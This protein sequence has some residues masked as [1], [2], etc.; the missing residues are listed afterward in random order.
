MLQWYL[1]APPSYLNHLGI[2]G[3]THDRH[4]GMGVIKNPSQIIPVDLFISIIVNLYKLHL[5]L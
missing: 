3:S 4:S 1:S 2:T 5:Q